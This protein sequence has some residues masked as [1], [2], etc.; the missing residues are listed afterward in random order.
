MKYKQFIFGFLLLSYS[1]LSF[2]QQTNPV[3]LNK[4]RGDFFVYWGWNRCSFTNSDITFKGDNYNFKLN[5][6]IAK[7]RQ[8][9][10]EIETYFSIT[11]FTIPQYD[12]RIGYFINDHYN[13]SVGSDHMKYV[14][15]NNQTVKISGFIKNSGTEYDG[16]YNN[17]DVVLKNN[18]L[19]F[20]HTDGLNYLNIEFRRFDEILRYKK[21]SLN[22]TEG[23]G[24]GMLVPRT[25]TTL[26]NNKRYDEFHLSGYGFGA[27]V[28]L[29][30][31]F[32]Q[33][34]FIQSE[35]KGGYINMPDIR[36]TILPSDRASQHF[37]FSQV[38]IVFG[39]SFNLSRKPHV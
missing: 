23:A 33:H 19:K 12:F 15:Q 29:N 37:L 14:M 39:A 21:L 1:I 36:T 34:Y 25:N 38:N 18:F 31:T 7:D 6:V 11:K 24:L 8:S 13:I 2:C 3:L 28:G 17:Q 20:E 9:P 5:D 27:I 16:V 30:L 10:F 32:F 26:L 4:H 22:V 35:L